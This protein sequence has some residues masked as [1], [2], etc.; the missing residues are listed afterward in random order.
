MWILRRHNAAARPHGTS[1]GSRRIRSPCPGDIT[2]DRLKRL[3][4]QIVDPNPQEVLP[5]SGAVY[6]LREN[7]E[8][9]ED[10]EMIAFIREGFLP[11][12]YRLRAKF[13][14][15]SGDLTQG[16]RAMDA[17]GF[18]RVVEWIS[19]FAGSRQL[20]QAPSDQLIDLASLLAEAS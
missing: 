1:W 13:A 14:T 7:P 16:P 12:T 18:H 8:D 15:T 20:P 2:V 6:V 4:G 19:T 17:S 3:L 5:K 10:D 11:H 9:L